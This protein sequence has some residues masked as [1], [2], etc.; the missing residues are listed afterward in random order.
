MLK[1]FV[2][3]C[4]CGLTFASINYVDSAYPR[5]SYHFKYE[6]A[7]N[8]EYNGHYYGLFSP[9]FGPKYAKF[10][11]DNGNGYLLR[12]DER[13]EDDHCYLSEENPTCSDI[14]VMMEYFY[15]PFPNTELAYNND[16]YPEPADC[17]DSSMTGCKKYCS[18]PSDSEPIECIIVD[19]KGYI[20]Q[21]VDGSNFTFYD[22]LTMDVFVG[23]KCDGK[24][25]FP[26]P[27]NFCEKMEEYIPPETGCSYH[28]K[29][30]D[31]T[32]TVD[33]YA[34]IDLHRSGNLRYV[35]KNTTVNGASTVAVVN[36]DERNDRQLCYTKVIQPNGGCMDE[37]YYNP[38]AYSFSLP[39]PAFYDSAEYPKPSKCPDGSEGCFKYCEDNSEYE[40]FI[41]DAD[42]QIVKSVYGQLWEYYDP[43]SMDV[44]KVVK[45]DGTDTLP[46]PSDDC[47]EAELFTPKMQDCSLN[48]TIEMSGAVTR[49]SMNAKIR[50]DVDI[51][52]V[53]GVI[54]DGKPLLA[55]VECN[56]NK[57]YEILRCDIKDTRGFCFDQFEGY[58]DCEVYTDV[59]PDQFMYYMSVDYLSTVPMYYNKTAYPQTVTCPGDV[60]GTDGCK[61][62][63][64]FG[65]YYCIFV[66]S[67]GFIVSDSY[68]TNYTYY[69]EL[70]LDVFDV[71][72]CNT[73]S[74][75]IPAPTTDYCGHSSS[76][77]TP[78]PTP[79][80]HNP[81]SIPVISSASMVKTA[82][83]FVAIALVMAL[84]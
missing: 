42:G 43:P 72:T 41:V 68:H 12:C 36:C 84:L 75:H 4:L 24:T 55:K 80:P 65:S 48:V 32:Y 2:L 83:T 77:A 82:F 34:V 64:A 50:D 19:T 25:T 39:D 56:D 78:T 5:C 81:S 8:P 67:S 16:Q 62:Y 59:D 15:P 52:H 11:G 70:S 14:Y 63:C 29:L 26:A 76:S 60:S 37:N 47:A 69:N 35:K 21:E 7:K 40:C 49:R 46:A 27:A 17:P 30:I 23:S 1:F 45:C 44:F 58:G 79:T 28:F 38:G 73:P 33:Y 10:V 71:D 20:V 9:Y 57:F 13:N 31:S 54:V 22:D 74:T 6:S 3:I 66:D 51:C 53:Y 61:V 18:V